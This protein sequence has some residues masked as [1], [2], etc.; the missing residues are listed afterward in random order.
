MEEKKQ[1]ARARVLHA[2]YLK[3]GVRIVHCALHHPGVAANTASRLVLWCAVLQSI[4]QVSLDHKTLELVN[5]YTAS[6][7][8]P[9]LMTALTRVQHQIIALCRL[10]HFRRFK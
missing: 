3:E 10:D 4:H 8:L 1:L 2:E 9:L 7:E 6:G 5:K